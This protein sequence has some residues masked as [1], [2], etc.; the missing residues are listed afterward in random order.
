[1]LEEEEK[2]QIGIERSYK[3]LQLFN[4]VLLVFAVVVSMFLMFALQI[5]NSVFKCLT[6][7]CVMCFFIVLLL[8]SSNN[9]SNSLRAISFHLAYLLLFLLFQLISIIGLLINFSGFTILLKPYALEILGDRKFLF[10]LTL[11][12]MFGITVSSY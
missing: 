8:Y 6:L 2:F 12:S 7:I 11:F 10:V 9:L 1:M 4:W 5:G 3:L